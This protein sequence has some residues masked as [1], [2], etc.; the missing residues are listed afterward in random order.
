MWLAVPLSLFSGAAIFAAMRGVHLLDLTPEVAGIAAAYLLP[1]I[2]TA[3]LVPFAVCLRTT[4]EGLGL[5]RPVMW[6]SIGVFLLNIPLDYALVHGV[7]G[8]PGLGGAGCGWASLIAFALL[9][10][11]WVL[12]T[13]RSPTMRRYR[14]WHAFSP[15]VR[16]DLGAILALGLPIG[17]SLLGVGGFFSV[18]PL[19]MAQLG[20]VA[21]AGHS[22]AMSVDM[23]ML[24]LP[25]GV[26]QAMSVRVAHE[27]GAGRPMAARQVCLAGLQLLIGIAL[28]QAS[29]I[30]MLRKQIATL[31][32]SDPQ[33]IALGASLLLFAAACRVFDSIQIG[34]G[35][36]LRGYKDTRFASGV[37]LASY[38]LFGL[39]L[40]YALGLTPLIVRP[41][42]VYGFWTGMLVCIALV[43]TLI[44]LRLLRTSHRALASPAVRHVSSSPG[45][46]LRA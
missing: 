16:R 43:S 36:A 6:L 9:L 28:L 26:G 29:L 31:F 25:L 38:W 37:N 4:A 12:Y 20:T 23:I 14:L 7:F 33:V 27:L 15:P 24:T 35:M 40:C 30:V 1:T 17:L 2:G 18:V 22:V 45:K 8:L 42:G 3:M 46:L 5:P 10:G 44:L 13:V 19:M 21:L 11:C 41:M 39:P 34:G 32:S